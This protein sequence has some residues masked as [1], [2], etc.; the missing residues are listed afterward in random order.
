MGYYAISFLS[1]GTENLCVKCAPSFITRSYFQVSE[2]FL[3][4]NTICILS[5]YKSLRIQTVLEVIYMSQIKAHRSLLPCCSSQAY[6]P[7]STLRHWNILLMIPKAN[8]ESLRNPKGR[9]NPEIPR[10]T[11]ESNSTT[12]PRA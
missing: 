2:K 3:G 10:Y 11:T 8:R 12:W 9:M 1:E 6:I 4:L 7:T 5:E